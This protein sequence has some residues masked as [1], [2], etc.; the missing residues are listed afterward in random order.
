MLSRR[1]PILN[2]NQWHNSS[3]YQDW[4][5]HASAEY[6]DSV[7]FYCIL[8]KGITRNVRDNTSE[9]QKI[10]DWIKK[11]HDGKSDRSDLTHAQRLDIRDS[12]FGDLNT[13][14]QN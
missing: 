5:S 1:N 13:G 8:E 14:R 2:T 12:V 4:Q 7:K 9:Q 11:K 3:F 6:V 10:K